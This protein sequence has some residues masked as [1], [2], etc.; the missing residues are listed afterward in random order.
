MQPG[1][2]INLTYTDA[3]GIQHQL[4]VVDVS[5][6]SA[7]PLSNAPNAN[8]Q[9]LGVDFSGGMS[10]V[11]SQ[12]NAA[13]NANGISF[14]NPSGNTLNIVGA[15]NATLTA[16]STTTTA[17]QLQDGSPALP[18][19]TD[20]TSL[21][22]GAVT[23][24]GSQMTGY[25]GTITVNPALLTNPS[26][27][28]IYNTSPQTAAGD[29][30]R[31]DYLFNQLSN[32]TFSYSPQTGLGSAA[33]PFSGTITNYLQQFLGQQGAAATQATNLQQG[34]DVVVSTLQQKFNSTSGVNLDTEMSNLIQ[35]QNAYAANAHVMSVIQS[36]MNT[37]LQAQT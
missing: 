14:S 18:L 24:G 5:D 27:L 17:T 10:S 13:L 7:L 28:S 36:M 3:T 12:L 35:L 32:A 2:T 16:A 19:F 6:S 4:Q 20:G 9:V 22:T 29:T 33:T 15:G 34:Q 8:P 26:A 37:L 1:N 21:Y 31:S 11:V 30:T 25:A 23:A